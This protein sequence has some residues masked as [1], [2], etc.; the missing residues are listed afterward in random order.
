MRSFALIALLVVAL[1][2]TVAHSQD[3]YIWELTDGE[4]KGIGG[5]FDVVDDLRMPPWVFQYSYNQGKSVTIGNKKYVIPDGVSATSVHR[6]MGFNETRLMNKWSDYWT[7]SVKNTAIKAAATFGNVTLD[8]AFSKTKGYFNQ[9]TKNG[10]RSFGY[11]GGVYITFQ[12]AFRGLQR[13]PLDPDFLYDVNHLPKSYDADTYG[14]FIKAWGTHFFTRALY[15]CSYNIT[16]SFDNQFIDQKGSKW[17]QSQLDLTIKYNQFEFGV[18]TSKEV[19]KSAIDGSFA[20]NVNVQA[21][22]RGGDELKFVMGHDFTGW[23]DSCHSMKVP[24]VLYSD[25]EPLTTLVQ[26]AAVKANLQRAIISYGKT[27]RAN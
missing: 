13:P 4:D 26:D 10:T 14:R 11:Q 27:G 17:S 8:A 20:D 2:A 7:H 1:T 19:N 21:N 5:G 15:G 24:I 9:L 18:K 12:L 25:V 22:A 3:P 6:Y 23:L 16:A